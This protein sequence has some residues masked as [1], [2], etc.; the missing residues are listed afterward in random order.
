[1]IDRTAILSFVF[2]FL[3]GCNG[4]ISGF[5]GGSGDNAPGENDPNLSADEL[6]KQYVSRRIW[7]LSTE[8]YQASIKALLGDTT[9][10]P[11]AFVNDPA[12]GGFGNAAANLRV[13]DSLAEQYMSAAEYYAERA[14]A[15]L[16]SLLPCS[17]SDGEDNCAEQ[18]IRDFAPKAFRRDVL[19]AEVTALMQ[20][21]SDGRE[22]AF[23]DGISNVIQTI[24][25]SPSFLYRTELGPADDMTSVVPLLDH[26]V[27]TLLAFFVTGAPPDEEL[28]AA[29]SAGELLDADVREAHARRLYSKAGEHFAGFVR[30]WLGMENVALMTKD[31]TFFPNFSEN[32]AQSMQTEIDTFV[33]KILVEGDTLYTTLMTANY[34]YIDS[35]L[36]S[37]YGVP[38]PSTA[39]SR[40]DFNPTQR[41]GL[42][43]QAGVLGTYADSRRSSPT[44]RG[45]FIWTRFLCNELGAPPAGVDTSIVGEEPP[46]GSTNRQV[47]EAHAMD[48]TCA[49][50]H[51][52]IDPLGFGL[53]NFDALGQ[54]RDTDNG[55]AVDASGSVYNYNATE[56]EGLSTPLT[57]DG[58]FDGPVELSWYLANSEEAKQCFV[59][60]VTEFMLGISRSQQE[61]RD[62]LA[63]FAY[64]G[65]AGADT[66]TLQLL[67]EIVRS[68]TF[69][70][71]ANVEGAQ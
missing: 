42:L 23:E 56:F 57:S 51:N 58:N 16:V 30:E 66:S 53:E 4:L 1:M 44:R 70:E 46:P 50:C 5:G 52:V 38:A 43:T 60:N 59:K 12:E 14:Q 31:E 67:V 71:R 7:R 21:Y 69:V 47:V 48:P 17:A 39:F 10:P 28:R 62:N 11:V 29:A 20:V 35:G 13:N 26:E 22:P 64:P 34:S 25:V 3:L 8:D 27:A 19:D 2:L 40:V 61:L 65:F 15:N 68:N 6:Q 41:A 45:K 9:L 49:G 54:W 24:L 63:A 55:S 32:T 33:E 18:F 37:L 36:A